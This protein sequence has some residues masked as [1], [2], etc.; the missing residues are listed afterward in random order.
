MSPLDLSSRFHV[1]G[2][3]DLERGLQKRTNMVCRS[4]ESEPV[5]SITSGKVTHGKQSAF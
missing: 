4:S 5:S 2:K 1:S 3:H